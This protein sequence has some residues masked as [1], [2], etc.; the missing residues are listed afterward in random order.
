M[1]YFD[2][3]QKA[4]AFSLQ[5]KKPQV[6]KVTKSRS[7]PSSA[8]P[9]VTVGRDISPF[10]QT[11]SESRACEHSK[12]SVVTDLG[13]RASHQWLGTPSK[14]QKRPSP[15]QRLSSDDDGSDTDTSFEV[16]KRIRVSASADSGINRRI[17]SVEA[18]SEVS[19]KPFRMVHAAD[20]A[21]AQEIAK[22]RR[23]F[24]ETGQPAEIVLQYPST[25]PGERYSSQSL[26]SIV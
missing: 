7:A 13:R 6:R 5:A 14:G 4:G 16:R 22:Y 20:I 15:A 9:P 19:Q 2:H 11:S 3:L 8:R 23:A 24:E 26:D 10:P 21:S 17:R 1:G 18:F 12:K 25:L